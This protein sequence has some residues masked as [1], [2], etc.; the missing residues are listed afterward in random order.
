MQCVAQCP[1]FLQ[2]LEQT[3]G[4]WANLTRHCPPR[5]S[6]E[7]MVHISKPCVPN[8]FADRVPFPLK[9]DLRYWFATNII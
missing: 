5:A 7:D 1:V 2:Q 9:G 8:F 3:W 6:L 4:P